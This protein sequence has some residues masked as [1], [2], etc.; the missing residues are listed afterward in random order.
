MKRDRRLRQ[1]QVLD[2]TASEG[3]VLPTGF[4]SLVSLYHD[5]TSRYGRINIVSADELSERKLR[6]GDTGVPAFAAVVDG[7]VGASQHYLRFAPEPSG[8]YALRMTYEAELTNLSAT[9]TSNWLLEQAPDLYL[10]ASLSAA[11]GF[12]QEDQRVGLWKNEYEQAAD[13]FEL[14]KKNRGYSGSLTPRPRSII[15]EDV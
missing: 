15:G 4:N 2:F 12:L 9:N 3:Y 6:H 14:N 7:P 13:E 10:W 11:E 5:G 1:T 8:T